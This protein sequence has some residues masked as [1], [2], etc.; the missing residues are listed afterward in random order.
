M[1][2]LL[3]LVIAIGSAVSCQDTSEPWITDRLNGKW[4]MT[5]YRAPIEEQPVLTTN[6][7]IWEFDSQNRKVTMTNNVMET[8]PYVSETGTFK[9][10]AKDNTITIGQDED[11]VMWVY[12]I[13]NDTLRIEPMGS[14]LGASTRFFKRI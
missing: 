9:L 3:L 13:E 11:E 1:K 14:P 10:Q 4:T 6:D 5:E 7:V 2:K 12:M 8:Y